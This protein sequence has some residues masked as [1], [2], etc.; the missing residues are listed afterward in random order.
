MCPDMS[1]VGPAPGPPELEKYGVDVSHPEHNKMRYVT[2]RSLGM[3]K[4]K[5]NVTCPGMLL[6]GP[7][8]G[9]PANEI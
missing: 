3:Q 2:S 6:V 5:F 9:P 1:L 7:A 8:S 4:H